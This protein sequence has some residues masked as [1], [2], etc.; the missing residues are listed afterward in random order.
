MIFNTK[1]LA[2]ALALV[3]VA[4]MTSPIGDT[5]FEDLDNNGFQDAGEPGIPGVTVDLDCNG[6]MASQVT[7]G[8]GN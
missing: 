4:G 8:N 1:I 2:G 5:V 7:D 3:L 6:N